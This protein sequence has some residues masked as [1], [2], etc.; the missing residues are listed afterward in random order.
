MTLKTPQVSP[1]VT[2]VT[3]DQLWLV[4][5]QL[6]G[7]RP[8]RPTRLQAT[9]APARDVDDGEGGTKPELGPGRRVRLSIPDL[10]KAI[11]EDPTGPLAIALDALIDAV[12]ALSDELE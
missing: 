8:N 2:E 1:A 7:A 4:D 10:H 5:L 6:S 12:V 9:L 11:A 3:Y